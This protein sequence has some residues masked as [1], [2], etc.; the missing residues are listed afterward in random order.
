LRLPFF[1]FLFY[2]G[3]GNGGENETEESDVPGL[4]IQNGD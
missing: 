4:R 2:N 1:A 3:L